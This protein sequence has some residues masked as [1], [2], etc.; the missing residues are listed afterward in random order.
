MAETVPQTVNYPSPESAPGSF[1]HGSSFRHGHR[2]APLGLGC[3]HDEAAHRSAAN[4]AL[5]LSALG[6]GVA[7]AIELALAVV[8]HSVGLLGDSL[9]NLS[10]V[11]TSVLVYFG[12]RVSKRAATRRFPYGYER[13]EDI[14]GLGVALVIW[15][16]AVFAGVESYHKLVHHS[17]TVH[18]A[19]G[20]V[21]ATIGMAANQIVARYK[22]AVGA[23]IQSSTLIADARHSWLDAISSSGALVGLALVALGI[24][25]GDPIAGFAIALFI[26]HV[27]YEVSSD[28]VHHLMDGIDPDI[29]RQVE[30]ASAGVLG[31]SP[32]HVR[33]RWTGRSLRI[34][35]V[36]KAD[37]EMTV[38]LGRDLADELSKSILDAVQEVRVVEIRLEPVSVHDDPTSFE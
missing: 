37:P 23:R 38:S 4:R 32:V 29:L 15:G 7:G 24:P 19:W 1:R 13:A 16:S 27:G 6:L 18:L 9:H 11:S 22:G 10:D 33:G 17:A 34:D 14:A 8:T 30:A 28:V 25:I 20:M 3:R 21:G 36:V 31:G 12:F 2:H 26:C 5:A 35:I